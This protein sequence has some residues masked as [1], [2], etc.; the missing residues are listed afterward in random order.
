MIFF[1]I[2][3]FAKTIDELIVRSRT[4][5]TVGRICTG[6]NFDYVHVDEF[7]KAKEEEELDCS[8]EQHIFEQIITS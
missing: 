5:N 6:S 3:F 2:D 4:V 7:N 8:A 1:R